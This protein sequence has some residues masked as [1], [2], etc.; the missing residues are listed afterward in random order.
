MPTHDPNNP[1]DSKLAHPVNLSS[2]GTESNEFTTLH[3]TSDA[4]SIQAGY[5]LRDA[6]VKDA[7]IFLVVLAASVGIVFVLV[8]GIG[9]LIYMELGHEDGA[10]NH[11]SQLTGARPQNLASNPEMEQQQL[12]QIVKKFPAPRLQ[13]DDGNM[14]VAEMHA[15]EDMLLNYYSWVDEQKQAVR[16]PITRAMQLI[17]QRGLPTEGQPATTGTQASS[18]PLMAGDSPDV[19]TRPLTDGF[20]RTATE[21][22]VM[23]AHQQQLLEPS[24]SR[25]TTGASH[26]AQ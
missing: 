10:A 9:K 13:T 2:R 16:I 19:V 8:F 26:T 1:L 17:A 20:A 7:A 22:Q 3:Q 11:W 25:S 12:N 6:N 4:G 5:E 23:A 14:D 15:R 24:E 21:L 18:E